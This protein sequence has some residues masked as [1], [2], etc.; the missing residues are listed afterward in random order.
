M[1][2][3][4]HR[5]RGLTLIE[6]VV[7]LSI[8]SLLVGLTSAFL[9]RWL[10]TY[11]LHAAAREVV[12]SLQKCKAAAVTRNRFC[13]VTFN[14]VLPGGAGSCDYVTYLDWDEDL[15]LDANE[16]VVR[17]VNFSG[18]KSGVGFDLAMG[19]GDGLTFA[20]ND[21]GRPSIAFNGRGFPVGNSL[22]FG[23]GS[24]FLV[25]EK[26]ERVKV[27]VSSMGRVRVE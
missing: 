9:L 20:R 4:T 8:L 13:T 7:V 14:A 17:A 18:Y 24:L 6:T 10:P 5:A 12:N 22:G 19:G 1:N 11:R 16:T 15:E 27:V 26:Q 23:S 3:S 21:N 25:N 2:R